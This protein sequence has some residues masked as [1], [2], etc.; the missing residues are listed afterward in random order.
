MPIEESCDTLRASYASRRKEVERACA[1]VIA[2]SDCEPPV[3]YPD[4]APSPRDVMAMVAGALSDCDARVNQLVHLTCEEYPCR[5]GVR[6]DA[7]LIHEDCGP[8][9]RFRDRVEGGSGAAPGQHS[10]DGWTYFPILPY[11][12]TFHKQPVEERAEAVVRLASASR[13]ASEASA[14]AG[15]ERPLMTRPTCADIAEASADL[16][17]ATACSALLAQWGCTNPPPATHHAEVVERH[18]ERV[19]DVVDELEESCPAA[20][21]ANLSLDCSS[22]PCALAFEPRPG[23]PWNTTLCNTPAFSSEFRTTHVRDA[24]G[25]AREIIVVPV[26]V[27]D[28]WAAMD[29]EVRWVEYG[30]YRAWALGQS[31]AQGG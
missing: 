28:D 4:I 12:R 13:R 27:P 5:F 23:E 21:S 26:Y 29:L 17:E 8:L 19:R 6:D 10:L 9:N 15:A 25:A 31:Y 1:A 18:V 7:F 3:P 24:G 22:L 2:A 14:S 16:T 30:P 20:A 11:D